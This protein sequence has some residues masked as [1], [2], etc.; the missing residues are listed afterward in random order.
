GIPGV[1]GVEC[2]HRPPGRAL[3]AGTRTDAPDARLL[4]ATRTRAAEQVGRAARAELT[5]VAISV[6]FGATRPAPHGSIGAGSR[7]SRLAL[8]RASHA[9]RA[10]PPCPGSVC[11]PRGG[12]DS[13]PAT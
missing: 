2:R 7:R 10:P 3:R 6:A 12:D 9:T 4:G 11:R 8:G 13:A 5:I 1:R